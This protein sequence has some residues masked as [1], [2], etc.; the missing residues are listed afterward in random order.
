M[1]IKIFGTGCCNCKNLYNNVKTAVED[2]NLE[3]KITKV[4]DLAQIAQFAIVA[5]PAIAINDQI[6]S[7]GSVLSVDQIKDLIN[8]VNKPKCCCSCCD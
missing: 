8:K 4:E 1:E 7:Q 6:L 3:C 2:L 5:T